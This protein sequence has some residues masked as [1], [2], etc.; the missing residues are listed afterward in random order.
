MNRQIKQKKF[1]LHTI[2]QKVIVKEREYHLQKF[3][4]CQLYRKE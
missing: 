1:P 4:L 2:G 3:Q